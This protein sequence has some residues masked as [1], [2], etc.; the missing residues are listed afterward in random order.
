M[1][2]KLHYS[3]E[4]IVDLVPDAS[5]PDESICVNDS[6]LKVSFIANSGSL[7]HVDTRSVDNEYS[8]DSEIDQPCFSE[9]KMECQ[10]IHPHLLTLLKVILNQT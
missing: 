1:M 2:L 3:G 7:T 4:S 5:E 9:S 8:A 6:Q 10:V